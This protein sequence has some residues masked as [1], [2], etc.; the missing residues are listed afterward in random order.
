M[1]GRGEVML[2]R[3]KVRS[4][5]ANVVEI[6]EEKFKLGSKDR[7]RKSSPTWGHLWFPPQKDA[8][9]LMRGVCPSQTWYSLALQTL[10]GVCVSLEDAGYEVFDDATMSY[11]TQL[12]GHLISRETA[13]TPPT[14]SPAPEPAPTLASYPS[15]PTQQTPLPSHAH[16]EQPQMFA[17]NQASS[18]GTKVQYEHGRATTSQADTQD[19]FFSD[20]QI[21]RPQKVAEIDIHGQEYTEHEIISQ[22]EPGRGT[23]HHTDQPAHGEEGSIQDL[24][25]HEESIAHG[26]ESLASLASPTMTADDNVASLQ[27]PPKPAVIQKSTD[28]MPS[29][30]LR[31]HSHHITSNLS[32]SLSSPTYYSLP[33]KTVSQSS[34]AFPSPSQQQPAHYVL[35][36]QQHQALF[37]QS[38]SS[39]SPLSFLLTQAFS[40]NYSNSEHHASHSQAPPNHFSVTPNDPHYTQPSIYYSQPS[41]TG[42]YL[43]QASPALSPRLSIHS[44]EHITSH[45]THL[46]PASPE[47]QQLSLEALA[48]HDGKVTL[49]QHSLH[50]GSPPS[51]SPSGHPSASNAS[52]HQNSFSR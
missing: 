21:P 10:R 43:P 6:N 29:E 19:S 28:E 31:A 52:G 22:E 42:L 15:T 46:T 27:K 44:P 20:Q 11:L 3:L 23:H 47:R 5:T 14:L 35:P 39:S 18:G 41:S 33:Q 40:S 37:A 50:Q 34:S 51:R 16:P 4:K 30:H 13:A 32:H 49:D 2:Y 36:N 8:P 26:R 9:R 45:S 38:P 25:G 7:N 12:Y 48:A 17:G 24:P 1:F